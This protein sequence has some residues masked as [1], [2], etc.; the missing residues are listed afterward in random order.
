MTVHQLTR[1][2][3][4]L[5]P[6]TMCSLENGLWLLKYAGRPIKKNVIKWSRKT[7]TDV[8]GPEW[9]SRKLHTVPWSVLSSAFR[10]RCDISVRQHSRRER[11]DGCCDDWTNG[12]RTFVGRKHSRFLLSTVEAQRVIHLMNKRRKKI[13]KILYFNPFTYKCA[14]SGYLPC[15]QEFSFFFQKPWPRIKFCVFV[16]FSWFWYQLI[17]NLVLRLIAFTELQ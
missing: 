14:I 5:K 8:I 12:W 15:F 4:S 6:T 13:E 16:W 3:N 10:S 9:L 17:E 11:F 7:A 2:G 1:E